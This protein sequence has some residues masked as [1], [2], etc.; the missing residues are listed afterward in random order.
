MGGAITEHLSWRWNWWINL[1]LS[2][3]AFAMTFAFLDVHNP[4]TE[5]KAGLKALDWLGSIG[6][7]TLTVLILLG[8][9]LGGVVFPWSS[10][11]VLGPISIG[12]LLTGAFVAWESRFAKNPLIPGRVVENRSN[13][14]A[15]VVCLCH[16]FVSAST[17]VWK[18]LVLTRKPRSISPRGTSYHF[19]FRECVKRHQ[20]DQVCLSYQ[21]SL[22]RLV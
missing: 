10:P 20:P 5:L 7:I 4:R 13:M 3:W 1:P 2:G 8:L 14:A 19:I 6:I 9:N 11:A 15:L 21:L 18:M 16:S 12:V 17:L 22:C